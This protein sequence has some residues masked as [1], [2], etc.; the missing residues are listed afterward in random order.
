[1]IKPIIMQVLKTDKISG[2]SHSGTNQPKN[3]KHLKEV[4]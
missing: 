3:S 2:K 4:I 1:M